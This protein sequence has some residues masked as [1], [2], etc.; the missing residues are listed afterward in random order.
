[1]FE[2]RTTLAAIVLVLAL[3]ALLFATACNV[4]ASRQE[5]IED[6]FRGAGF[7]RRVEQVGDATLE[8][9]VGGEGPDLLLLHGFGASAIWQWADQIE[10]FAHDHR[11][12]V[13]N[14]LWF[15][16]SESTSDDY[17]LDHQVRVVAALLDRLG[18]ERA[19]VLGLS[20]GG[21]VAY[22][23]AARH[24][25]RIDRLVLSDSPGKAYRL[26]DYEAAC[27]RFGVERLS[28]LLVPSDR[29]GV[30]QLMEIGYAD[31]PWVP[32]FALD[33]VLDGLYQEHRAEKA[34]LLDTIVADWPAL[35]ETDPTAP[36]LLIWGR[37]DTVF[38]LAI[39]ERL[40]Q[41]LGDRAALE[42]IDDARHAPNLEHPDQFNALVLGFLSA[43]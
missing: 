4:V 14:L 13:P 33:Q 36:T 29:A 22:E 16:A 43:R 12:I 32:G 39:G 30:R 26:D 19:H 41:R 10:P 6:R 31:P 34:A 17:G 40:Q 18:S 25:E 2:A 28:T 37:D 27:E 42:I 23:L 7:E 20:Y 9:W 8:Y 3:G 1:M 35:D 24:P 21:L 11:V 38:P 5:G 15:G